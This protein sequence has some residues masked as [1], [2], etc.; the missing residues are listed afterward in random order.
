MN[1][2]EGGVGG[3]YKKPYLSPTFLKRGGGGGFEHDIYFGWFVKQNKT[4]V[5]TFLQRQKLRF[6]FPV[7]HPNSL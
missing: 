5:K 7:P 4:G 6:Y 3:S 2:D 1:G